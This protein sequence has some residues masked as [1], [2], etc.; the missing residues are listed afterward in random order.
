MPT[1]IMNCILTLA[2]FY[3]I[4]NCILTLAHFYNT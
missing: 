1:F 4:M 2:H 3:N